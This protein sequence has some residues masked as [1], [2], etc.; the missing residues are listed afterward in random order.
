MLFL[1]LAR[2][3]WYGIVVLDSFALMGL[4]NGPSEQFGN[5][6]KVSQSFMID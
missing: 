4:N 5:P 3:P 1:G 2:A 6:L